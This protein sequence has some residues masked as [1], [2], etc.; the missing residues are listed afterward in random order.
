MKQTEESR[1]LISR[2]KF[3]RWVLAAAGLFLASSV[4]LV[5]N[6]QNPGNLGKNIHSDN[7]NLDWSFLDAKL[8][9]DEK[10]AYKGIEELLKNYVSLERGPVIQAEHQP[11]LWRRLETKYGPEMEAYMAAN[12]LDPKKYGY[13]FICQHLAKPAHPRFAQAC[14]DYCKRAFDFLYYRVRGLQP[15]EFDW[16]IIKDGQDFSSR[17]NMKCFI[18]SRYYRLYLARL[19]NLDTML[20]IGYDGEIEQQ[21]VGNLG[22]FDVSYPRGDEFAFKTYYVFVQANRFG[23]AGPFSEVIPFT[24]LRK[25]P[26]VLPILGY[27]GAMKADETIVEGMSHVLLKE[28]VKE[29]NIPHGKSHADEILRAMIK[30]SKHAQEHWRY[31]EVSLAIKWIEQNGVQSAF[32]LYMDSPLKFLSA[33]GAKI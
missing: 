19:I 6:L 10:T 27:K 29:I 3:N 23:L 25:L 28:L 31:T 20:P 26:E 7:S 14:L 5:V 8:K 17:E 21:V 2:R 16:T 1:T 9:R 15:A 4:P 13:D 22:H 18:G 32:D 11:E 30:P 12:N 24:T 33:I